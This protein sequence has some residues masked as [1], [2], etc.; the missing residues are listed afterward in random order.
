MLKLEPLKGGIPD[1][2][3]ALNPQLSKRPVV[4]GSDAYNMLPLTEG[5]VEEFSTEIMELVSTIAEE[6]VKSTAAIESGEEEDPFS[7]VKDATKKMLDSGF[8][9]RILSKMTGL[10]V[11]QIRDSTTIPQMMHIAGTVYELNFDL[12]NYP[13]L[14]RGKVGGMLDFLGI[15]RRGAKRFADEVLQII[16]DP[17]INT[18]NSMRRSIF[19]SATRSLPS[20]RWSQLSPASSAWLPKTSVD[21]EEQTADSQETPAA[22]TLSMVDSAVPQGAST[23]EKTVLTEK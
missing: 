15:G 16:F 21:D 7:A 4:I 23:L 11:D 20:E 3:K 10:T 12:A 2:L 9:A 17:T 6:Y 18:V 22:P 5:D 14:T 8:L 1:D 13:E 19:S